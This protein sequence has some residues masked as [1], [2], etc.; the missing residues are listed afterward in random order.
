VERLPAV[1]VVAEAAGVRNAVARELTRDFELINALS[2]ASAVRKLSAR[3]SLAAIIVDLALTDRHGASWFLARLVDYAYDG[4]RILLSG[5]LGA[6]HASSMRRGSV[7]HFT[8]AR[9]WPGGELR[10]SIVTALG[11][12]GQLPPLKHV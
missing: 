5:A 11:F 10:S 3:P 8:L 12:Y 4:P 9:P 1:L 7:S 6:E 2:F